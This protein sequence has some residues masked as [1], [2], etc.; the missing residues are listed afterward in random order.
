MVDTQKALI[1]ELSNQS[2]QFYAREG[3]PDDEQLVRHAYV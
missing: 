2:L 3:T 1:R